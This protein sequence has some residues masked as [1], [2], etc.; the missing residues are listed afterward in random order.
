MSFTFHLNQIS[1]IGSCNHSRGGSQDHLHVAA[2]LQQHDRLLLRTSQD[3]IIG[4]GGG[5][6]GGLSVTE[7]FNNTEAVETQ[8]GH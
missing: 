8:V 5:N 7:D 4:G 3:G 2:E 1:S 6:N